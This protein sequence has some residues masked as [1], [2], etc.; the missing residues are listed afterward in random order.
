MRAGYIPQSQPSR[1]LFLPSWNYAEFALEMKRYLLEE[2][3]LMP[4]ELVQINF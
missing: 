2:F 4:L 3:S 1:S